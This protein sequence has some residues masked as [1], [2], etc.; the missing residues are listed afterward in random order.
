MEVSVG[1]LMLKLSRYID[2][3]FWLKGKK[4]RRTLKASWKIWQSSEN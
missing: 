4:R 2:L 3:I 1:I